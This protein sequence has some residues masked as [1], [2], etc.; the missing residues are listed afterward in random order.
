MPPAKT[1]PEPLWTAPFVQFTLASLAATLVFYVLM[2]TTASYAAAAYGADPAGAGLAASGFMVG[3]VAARAASGYLFVRLGLR[4]VLAPA[5]IACV[6]STAAYLL[7]FSL[8]ALIAVRVINGLAFG[9]TASALAGAIMGV[10]PVS[11]RGSGAGWSGAAIA[12]S[13]G[14]GPFAGLALLNSPVGMT[15][16]FVAAVACALACAAL[17]LPAARLLTHHPP[18][19]QGHPRAAILERGALAVGGVVALAALGFSIV[20][21]FLNPYA[22][23]SGLSAAAAAYFPCYA[24][25]L[26]LTRPLS[27]ALQDRRGDD[28]VLIP[29]L[30]LTVAGMAC[31]AGAPSAPVLL[32]GAVLL[33]AG[34]GTLISAGQAFAV[35]RAPRGHAGVAVASFF[36][37]VDA[38]TGAGPVLL[39]ALAPAIGFAGIFWCGAVLGL[40][41]LISY[42]LF[43]RGSPRLVEA[44]GSTP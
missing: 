8:P 44:P 10:V 16:V 26:L 41:A 4:R 15:G 37:L 28:V 1:R 22:R 17:A 3:A 36:L 6:L 38:G 31:T 21:A 23:E 7:T 13:S 30:A 43:V 42:V 39:G 35:A 24:G 20:L 14:F 9:V 25:A 11:R 34:Y 27:G 19:R 33:G 32:A 5:L 2:S 18:A 40:A 29:A 12:L